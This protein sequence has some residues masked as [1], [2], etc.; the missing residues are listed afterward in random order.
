MPAMKLQSAA[1]T[2]VELSVNQLVEASDEVCL[3]S[4]ES[5]QQQEIER[6]ERDLE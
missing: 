4:S 3:P 2:T 1:L 6:E 5:A